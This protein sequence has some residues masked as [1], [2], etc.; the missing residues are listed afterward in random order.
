[1]FATHYFELTELE[2]LCER[3]KNCHITVRE[4]KDKII[5]LRKIKDGR[6]DKSYGIHV[7][8]LAG[9]PPDV[10]ERAREILT[11]LE[12]NELDPVGK[13]RL[14]RSRRAIDGRQLV[15]FEPAVSSELIDLKDEIGHIKIDQM[16]PLDA[17]NLLHQIQK[18]VGAAG[19]MGGDK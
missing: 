16:T 1:M 14:A 17:L 11:N 15:L 18:K 13:P 3:V 10:I 9:L 4:A 5:F 8:A 12:S 6:A 19:G 7:A 2:L